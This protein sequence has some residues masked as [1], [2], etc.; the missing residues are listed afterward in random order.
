MPSACRLLSKE[1]S[2]T[3]HQT[4][5]GAKIGASSALP[6]I[7]C[8]LEHREFFRNRTDDEL[9]ANNGYVLAFNNL[10]GLPNWLSD[11]PLPA[12]ER[13]QLRDVAARLR[14]PVIRCQRIITK[15]SQRDADRLRRGRRSR[16]PTSLD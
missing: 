5:K 1:R 16:L 11:G 8:S 9:A 12:R 10:P 3:S 6:K 15:R 7:I 2:R 4:I 14:G 13:R